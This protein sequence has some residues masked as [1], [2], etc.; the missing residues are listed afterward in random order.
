MVNVFFSTMQDYLLHSLLLYIAIRGRIL[1]YNHIELIEPK[2]GDASFVLP[3]HINEKA[4][5]IMDINIISIIN[6][7]PLLIIS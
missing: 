4:P 6:D 1:Q 5:A 3:I 2:V 7:N